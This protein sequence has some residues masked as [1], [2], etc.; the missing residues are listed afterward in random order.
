[1]M[2]NKIKIISISFIMLIALLY[3]KNEYARYLL[4]NSTYG[5]PALIN[6]GEI[7]NLFL[8][9]SMFRQGIDID[10]LDSDSKE[11]N[12]ILS[13][14]GNQLATEYIELD[15]LINNGVKIHNLFVDMYAYGINATPKI[16]DEKLF[17]ETD[18]PTKKRL[19]ECIDTH[20][21][22]DWWNMF[23]S[24]NNELLLEWPI[25]KIIIDSRFRNGG[26]L[27]H[28]DGM[29]PEDFE[30]LYVPEFGDTVDKRQ[31]DSLINIINLC[32]NN[33]INLIFV[34][35]P[36]T[37]AVLEDTVYSAL[38]KQYADIL[39]DNNIVFL[40]QNRDYVFCD[41][42]PIYFQDAIHLSYEG[43]IEFTKILKNMIEGD[44]HGKK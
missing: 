5:M 30:H 31:I 18:V 4:N 15:Y 20:N 3:I 13:Y 7:D 37:T 25:N 2:K 38:V 9:S 19:W 40:Q 12:Y 17:I 8:G 28:S 23:I 24:S 29:Q 35:T 32:K 43:R 6:R 16:S 1:M 41:S 11:S 42:N 10:V 33:N 39:A 36:K 34:D 22:E 27:I 44:N 14:N 26:T 21:F